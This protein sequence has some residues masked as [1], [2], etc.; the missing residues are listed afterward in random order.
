[1]SVRIVA[2]LIAIALLPALARAEPEAARWR[3]EAAAVSLV[4]DDWGIAHVHGRTDAEAVFG[5]IYAQAEDDFPRIEANYLTNLGRTAQADGE[6]AVWADLRQRLYIDDADLKARYAASPRWL[7][8]L[9]D[10]WADGLNFYLAT[11]PAVHPRAL[12]HLEPW[13]ALSF[14]EGS[15]GGDIE[16]ISLADLERFYGKHE[17]A[18]SDVEPGAVFEEPRGSNGIAIAPALTAGGHALLLINPHTSFYFRSE[19]QVTSDEGL[20]AYGAATWGQFFVYQGF[21]AQ[22]GWMHTSTGLV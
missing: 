10:A 20:N 14:T 6:T 1:M 9:M 8:A 11:H 22:A 12:T 21:N 13:M 3:R 7:K 2:V 19:A 17:V 18:R 16:R 4:R 15:I 5:M